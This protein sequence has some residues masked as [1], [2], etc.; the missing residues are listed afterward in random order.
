[1][2]KKLCSVW[3]EVGTFLIKKS[4]SLKRKPIKK[5]KMSQDLLKWAMANHG[6]PE[7]T[8]ST[9]ISEF[10]SNISLDKY[11][12]YTKKINSLCIDSAEKGNVFL[13]LTKQ[14]LDSINFPI[15]EHNFKVIKTFLQEEGLVVVTDYKEQ[16]I[17]IYWINLVINKKTGE[18][19][20]GDKISKKFPPVSDKQI[21]KLLK[22]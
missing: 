18:K 13:S 12:N 1:M 22:K 8:K 6:L 9:E 2:L 21:R 5:L 20:G 16:T 4:K 7:P 3:D 19:M 10:L 15:S 17:D 11:N 14:E